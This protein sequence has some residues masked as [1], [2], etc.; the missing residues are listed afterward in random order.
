MI[1][2]R[3][4]L[5]KIQMCEILF[6]D[7]PCLTHHAQIFNRQRNQ[8]PLP[9]FIHTGTLRKTWTH[10]HQYHAEYLQPR[11][12]RVWPESLWCFIRYF[13]E[14]SIVLK[15]WSPNSPLRQQKPPIFGLLSFSYK[16][17]KTLDLQGFHQR[18]PGR[19]RTG[20]LRI[21]NAL[22]YQLSHGSTFKKCCCIMQQQM[23]CP[24][25]EPGFT[26]WEGV[27]L[28]AWPRGQNLSRGDK[29]RTCDLCVPNAALYQTEP[30]LVSITY[31][32]I[33]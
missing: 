18:A 26:P 7:D 24:G 2:P 22:L 5:Q 15:F 17:T 33:I 25:I 4:F 19:T 8:F 13:N 10:Q 9:Q 11:S 20:D 12:G 28:T 29:I 21:T 32:S 31:V 27:V 1:N 3:N 30:R 16:T 6:I 23:T 14:K